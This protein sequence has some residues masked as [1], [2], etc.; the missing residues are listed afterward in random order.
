MTRLFREG[1]TETVRSCT[2]ETSAFVKAMEAGVS[3]LKGISDPGN[4]SCEIDVGK[5]RIRHKT[6]MKLDRLKSIED[7][8]IWIPSRS[9]SDPSL[10][11]IDLTCTMTLVWTNLK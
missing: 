9:M 2:I 5:I 3:I 4:F 1:R 11:D 7:D 6:T 8:F 10:S